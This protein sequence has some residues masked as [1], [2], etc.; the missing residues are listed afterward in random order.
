MEGDVIPFLQEL[1]G[2]VSDGESS[3][4]DEI[5]KQVRRDAR[6]RR[7]LA[8][9]SAVV[10]TNPKQPRTALSA[11]ATTKPQ[12]KS[13]SRSVSSPLPEYLSM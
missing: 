8:N 10:T 9:Q 6:E 2:K 3:S 5:W 11:P 12:T 13:L 7:H 1:E 4:D